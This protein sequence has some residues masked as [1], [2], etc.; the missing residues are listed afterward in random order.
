[1]GCGRELD[2]ITPAGISYTVI[3]SGASFSTGAVA[4]SGGEIT[5]A[6]RAAAVSGDG[7]TADSSFGMYEATTNLIPNSDTFS[8]WGAPYGATVAVV[9]DVKKFGTGAARLTMTQDAVATGN[10]VV[11]ANASC[12]RG[13]CWKNIYLLGMDFR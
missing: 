13:H 7:R 3:N 11:H 1:L 8:G 9:S 10:L 4:T 6:V 12:V 5:D 2:R